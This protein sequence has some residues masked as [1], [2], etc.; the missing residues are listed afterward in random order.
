MC[1]LQK[2][3]FDID[4]ALLHMKQVDILDSRINDQCEVTIVSLV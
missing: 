2:L 3:D 1:I 4:F